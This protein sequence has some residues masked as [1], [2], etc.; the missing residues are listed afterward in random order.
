[1]DSEGDVGIK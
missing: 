1:M